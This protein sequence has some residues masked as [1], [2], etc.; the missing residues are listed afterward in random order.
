MK[1]IIAGSFDKKSLKQS[2]LIY[3]LENFISTYFKDKS[4]GSSIEQIYITFNCI[5]LGKSYRTGLIVGFDYY[6][7][8][9]TLEIEVK[10]NVKEL[11]SST[12]VT[13][14]TIAYIALSE[15]I[16]YIL[17]NKIKDFEAEKFAEVFLRLIKNIELKN[18]SNQ[19]FIYNI[20]EALIFK[21]D[22][23]KT[24][25]K[26]FKDR[27]ELL[28][29]LEKSI[30]ENHFPKTFWKNSPFIMSPKEQIN[31]LNKNIAVFLT[32]YISQLKKD[33]QIES[34]NNIMVEYIDMIEVY[35]LDTVEMDLLTDKMYDF[36]VMLKEIGV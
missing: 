21:E 24:E 29:F 13:F 15:V 19:E 10:I 2:N 31:I 6:K 27:A 33:S 28:L 34:I 30:H 8:K 14:P 22:S 26:R 4:Y 18:E 32:E 17:A 20:S 16:K 11:V 23:L 7:T 36:V 1:V 9:R 3:S 12:I 5:G 25:I 35:E